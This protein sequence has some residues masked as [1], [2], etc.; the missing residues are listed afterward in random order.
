MPSLF[1]S[2]ARWSVCGAVGKASSFAIFGL[3]VGL[4]GL[5][6]CLAVKRWYCCYIIHSIFLYFSS[7]LFQKPPLQSITTVACQSFGK[8]LKIALTILLPFPFI[9]ELMSKKLMYL[10]DKL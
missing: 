6:M 8:S 5:A 7:I 1:F 3:C 2:V 10:C 9:G 4:W